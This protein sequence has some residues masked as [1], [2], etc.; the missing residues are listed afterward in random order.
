MRIQRKH[1]FLFL[2]LLCINQWLCGQHATRVTDSLYNEYKKSKNDTLKV[3]ALLNMGEQ[4]FGSNPDSSYKIW[5]IGNELAANTIKKVNPQ[6]NQ[7]KNYYRLYGSALLNIG[8]YFN[9]KGKSDLALEYYEKAKAN[10]QIAEYKSGLGVYA[11]NTGE[12]FSTRG[13]FKKAIERFKEAELIFLE[14]NDYSSL[15][16]NYNNMGNL[17]NTSGF[18]LE[19]IGCY[20]TCLKYTALSKNT[21][22]EA[23]VANNLA[24]IYDSQGDIPRAIENYM[25]AVKKMEELGY[26]I[27]LATVK[28]NLSILYSKQ[29]DREKSL[30]LLK[31]SLEYALKTN[32]TFAIARCYNNLGKELLSSNKIEESEQFYKKAEIEF[33]K[34]SEKKGLAALYNNLGMLYEKKGNLPQATMYFEK[35]L[36]LAEE[37]PDYNV[38]AASHNNIGA[39][40]ANYQKNYQRAT[41]EFEKGLAAAKKNGNVDMIK[42]SAEKLKDMYSK[43]DRHAMAIE[44]YD[45]FM[46]M[47]DS[48]NNQENKKASL[49]AMIKYDY[50]KKEALSKIEFEKQQ[51]ISN[52]ELQRKQFLIE[53]NN[54][55]LTLL[56]RENELSNLQLKTRDFELK[57][58]EAESKAKES[59]IKV[60]NKDKKLKEAQAIQKQEEINRQKGLLYITTIGGILIL[61]FLLFAIRA[62]QQKKKDNALISQQKIIVEEQK[63]ISETQRH[64]V[65]EKQKEI[66][67]SINYAKRIQY[68]LLAHQDFLDKHLP[69]HFVYF[70]PK[71]I[72][73]GDFYW[74]THIA[75][76][77]EKN[78]SEKS[79]KLY[80]AVCDSTGHGVPGAF[81]S[82][83]NISFLSEAIN[84]KRIEKPN[85]VFE[86]VRKRLIENISKEKQKDGFDG[87]LIC[88]D[89]DLRKIMYAAAN[90][91]PLAIK[92][93][94]ILELKC[95]RMPVGIGEKN[96]KF[97]NFELRMEEIDTLYLYTDGYADQFGGPKGKKFKYKP[98]NELLL[99]NQN[100]SFKEQKKVLSDN[101]HDWRGELEQVD[102][103]CIAGISFRDQF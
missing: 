9:N 47:R 39:Y 45:L 30:E 44:M 3:R 48:L 65:E 85:E 56:T 14:I 49:K 71:D 53:Q 16:Y 66:L 54:Q 34:L 26:L 29:G 46:K 96:E 82:L 87:I 18:V 72:V 81:M 33:E 79:G 37:V 57:R 76:E 51:A 52:A 88:I 64:L 20:K 67:D 55:N 36:K 69:E 23:V 15:G 101:F 97:S 43:T 74:A 91:A 22:L 40:Y 75:S 93:N 1:N 50:E 95:D 90:N 86:F 7:R 10:Y 4:L 92:N 63:K 31:E 5:L 73:S 102:D 19:A 24:F 60:L 35:A 27:G 6:G 32:N 8:F 11:T 38:I 77:K 28:N 12:I 2:F 80:L 21:Q 70:N 83:L 68:T 84:E 17:Y 42:N 89:Y 58:K 59:E 62:Y 100:R 41:E 94:E 25:I 61:A 98:L 13:D 99:A 78:N 103:V